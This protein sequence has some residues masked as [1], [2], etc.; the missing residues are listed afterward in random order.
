MACVLGL[1]LIREYLCWP[2]TEFCSLK[3]GTCLR[4]KIFIMAMIP[5]FSCTIVLLG[6]LV[7][8]WYGW[9]SL[10]TRIRQ[11][12]TGQN[13][14]EVIE[15]QNMNGQNNEEQTVGHLELRFHMNIFMMNHIF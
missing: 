1:Y 9:A 5:T 12:L 3:N 7:E 14:D 2:Q 8:D 6:L 11:L 13:G 15:L 4:E 10:V